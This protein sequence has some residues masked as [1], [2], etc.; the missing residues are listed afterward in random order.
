MPHPYFNKQTFAQRF[1]DTFSSLFIY[2]IHGNFVVLFALD[3]IPSQKNLYHAPI[4]NYF[5]GANQPSS[6]VKY[7]I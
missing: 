2:S 3:S 1:K 6:L 5:D 4:G 7:K